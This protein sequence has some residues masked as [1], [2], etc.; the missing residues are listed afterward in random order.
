YPTAM[1][2]RLRR[3]EQPWE[4]VDCKAVEPVPMY[5]DD[6]DL[7]VLF[8]SGAD[9][10]GTYVFDVR[11]HNGQSRYGY[12]LGKAVMFAQQQLLREVEKKGF[13]MLLIEGWSLTLLRKGKRNRLEVQYRARAAKS[14]I[15]RKH[16]RPPPFM[17]VL[18]SPH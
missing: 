3:K 8:I 17:G 14:R 7:D 18:H 6:E 12:Q 16:H 11:S 15:P 1:F 2:L 4:V 9:T 5:Y 13:D 10:R